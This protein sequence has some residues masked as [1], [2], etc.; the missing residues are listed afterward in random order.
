MRER[1]GNRQPR[2]IHLTQQV[3]MAMRHDTSLWLCQDA[4]WSQKS[5]QGKESNLGPRQAIRAVRA[6][7]LR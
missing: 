2:A 1:A 3:D 6:V 4:S 5:D 7:K